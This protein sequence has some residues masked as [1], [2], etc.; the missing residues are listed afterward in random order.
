MNINHKINKAL[1]EFSLGNRESAYQKLK[2]LFNENKE[3]HLLRFNLAVVEQALNLNEQAKNNY[4][5]LVEKTSHL[6]SMVNLYLLY[7]KE[8]NFHKALEYDLCNQ[9]FVNHDEQI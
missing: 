6:K 2:K 9:S 4:N 7:L 1:K 3:N 8:D 5:F